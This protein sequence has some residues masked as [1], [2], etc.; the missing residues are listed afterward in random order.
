MLANN[1]MVRSTGFA[2]EKA[3]TSI[4]LI[5]LVVDGVNVS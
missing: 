1:E 2:L 5:G 3:S 4:K